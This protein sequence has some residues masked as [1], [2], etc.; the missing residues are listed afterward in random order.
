MNNAHNILLKDIDQETLDLAV[1][2]IEHQLV[3]AYF[4]YGWLGKIS[5]DHQFIPKVVPSY[6][7]REKNFYTATIYMSGSAAEELFHENYVSDIPSKISSERLFNDLK[8]A[9]PH[10]LKDLRSEGKF[11]Y[12]PDYKDIPL[13]ICS[14]YIHT[15]EV[16]LEKIAAANNFNPKQFLENRVALYLLHGTGRIIN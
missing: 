15:G 13:D 7:E 9:H 8:Y 1:H 4:R 12:Y 2:H 16:L 11:N 5:N 14:G 10:I 6:T 3:A